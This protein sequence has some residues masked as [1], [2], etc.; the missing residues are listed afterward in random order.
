MKILYAARL[1]RFDLLR[2]ACHLATFVPKWTSECDHKLYR[3]VCYIKS[4]KHL[5]MIGWGGDG[6][7]T[8]QPHLFA[9]ADSC[10]V[11]GDSTKHFRISFC[12]SGTLHLCPD[13]GS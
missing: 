1:C 12:G 2:A 5:R 8:L 6:P 4:S 9:D 13:D 7:S 11:Y 10:R 3:H